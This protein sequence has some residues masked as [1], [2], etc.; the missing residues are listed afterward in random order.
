MQPSRNACLRRDGRGLAVFK[1]LVLQ[2]V[3]PAL[4]IILLKCPAS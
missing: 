3:L 4:S 2:Q 1:N